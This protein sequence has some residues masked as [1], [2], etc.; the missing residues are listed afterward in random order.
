M[1]NVRIGYPS[2]R[3]TTW[4]TRHVMTFGVAMFMGM[5]GMDKFTGGYWVDVFDAIGFGQWLRY[6][7][8]MLQIAGAAFLVFRRTSLFGAFLLAC[9]MAGA[10]TAQLAV[11]GGWAD[12]MI[13]ASLLLMILIVAAVE[14]VDLRERRSEA[15]SECRSH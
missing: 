4:H 6:F 13:P 5:V 8:G 9:T 3:D 15:R 7:T 12:A 14:F 1:N 11:L 10:I 2:D